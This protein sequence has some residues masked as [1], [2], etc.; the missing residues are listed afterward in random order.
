MFSDA[1]LQAY[2]DEAAAPDRMAAIEESARKDEKVCARLAGLV[3]Q[4]DA[5]LHSLGE[6]WRRRRL[7]CPSREQLGS[8][9]MGVLDEAYAGYVAFHLEVIECRCCLAN[10]ED[11][12]RLHAADESEPAETR[13]KKFFQS[14]VGRIS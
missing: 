7:T 4:R 14:S 5:G 2:L 8:H 9:L 13:R 1:E 6:V 3:G 10:L 11:L 12:R